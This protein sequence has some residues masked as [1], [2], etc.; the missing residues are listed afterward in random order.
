MLLPVIKSRIEN[1]KAASNTEPEL[2]SIQWT[3]D[4]FPETLYEFDRRRFAHELLHNLWAGSAAPG[5]MITEV[6]FQL[7]LRQGEFLAVKDEVERSHAEYGWSER[8]IN[9]LSLLDSF[10]RETNRLFPT[11]SGT[12]CSYDEKPKDH[13]PI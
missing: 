10:I 13:R 3:L 7:L 8:M 9:A 12:F 6:I 11:G 4:L 5:G 1:N 2:D